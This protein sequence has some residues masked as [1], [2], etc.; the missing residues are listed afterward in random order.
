MIGTERLILRRPDAGDWPAYAAFMESPA[1]AFFAAR[2]SRAKA[3][4]SYGLVIWHW[5][6]LGFGPF[7]VTLRGAARAVALVGPKRPEGWPEGEI[8]WIAFPGAEGRGIAQEA[9]RAALVHARD[10]LG[11]RTAVS[12]IEPANARSVALAER[13]GARR[14]DGAAT[15]D[16][17]VAA[18]RHD[19]GAA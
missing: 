3:W 18:W 19:L 10:A 16:P 12:Y 6:H 13:L 14:D 17:S 4:K 7:A 5:V 15:P 1:A 8:T 9:A 11:W 2:G